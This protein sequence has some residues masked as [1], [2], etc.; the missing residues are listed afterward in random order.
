MSGAPARRDI[1]APLRSLMIG[2]GKSEA[3]FG[4]SGRS[5]AIIPRI[6][7]RY[8][9]RL[10]PKV[11]PSEWLILSHLFN[12]I[13]QANGITEIRV[14]QSSLAEWTGMSSRRVKQIIHSLKA[15]NYLGVESEG[16]TNIYDLTALIRAV[17]NAAEAKWD[18]EVL[19]LHIGEHDFPNRGTSFPQVGEHPFPNPYRDRDESGETIGP[20][21]TAVLPAGQPADS[22]EAP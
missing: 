21:T 6:V 10:D 9:G 16:V 5:F 18:R 4:P 13:R 2:Q 1:S 11:T 15:K 20:E 17:E 7:I 14:R 19:R 3:M 22:T 12:E 8:I